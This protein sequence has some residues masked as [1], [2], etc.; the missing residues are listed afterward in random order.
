ME[1]EDECGGLLT[2]NVKE[3]F[4]PFEQQNA[5]RAGLGA[6]ACFQPMGH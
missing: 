3:L 1:V 4:R 2:G 6:W 5:N